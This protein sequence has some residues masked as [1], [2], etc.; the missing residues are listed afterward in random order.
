MLALNIFS[1]AT[2]GKRITDLPSLKCII[3]EL[4]RYI[5]SDSSLMNFIYVHDVINC[6][7]DIPNKG[8]KN[9]FKIIFVWN[10]WNI[11]KYVSSTKT[12]ISYGVQPD[13][14]TS[15]SGE[16][17]YTFSFSRFVVYNICVTWK[18]KSWILHR[19]TQDTE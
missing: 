5:F 16:N 18:R 13:L 4:R 8:P 7:E 3:M 10:L 9:N 12:A 17:T 11:I 14:T 15:T 19:D 2:L 6:L 1:F